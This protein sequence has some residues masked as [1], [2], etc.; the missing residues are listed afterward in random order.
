MA[1]QTTG[2]SIGDEAVGLLSEMLKTNATL[3]SLSLGGLSEVRVR[4][5]TFAS[6]GSL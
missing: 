1:T 3:M 4:G 6:A 2:N 5:G